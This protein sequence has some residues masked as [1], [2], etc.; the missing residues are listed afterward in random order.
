MDIDLPEQPASESESEIESAAPI[1]FNSPMDRARDCLR[2]RNWKS[3][4]AAP[5]SF[6]LSNGSR[7][8]VCESEIG[9]WKLP[10]RIQ[11]N[12]PRELAVV[13]PPPGF[14]A[15]ISRCSA[16]SQVVCCRNCLTKVNGPVSGRPPSIGPPPVKSAKSQKN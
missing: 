11:L 10:R 8:I 6:E 7:A 15:E 3:E 13:P 2:I 4:I 9:N 12:Y 1:P 14:Y 5:N 16:P